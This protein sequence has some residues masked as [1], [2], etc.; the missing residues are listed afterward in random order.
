MFR[1]FIPYFFAAGHINYARYG[2]YYLRAMECLPKDVLA[3]FLKGEHV[4]RHQSGLWNGMWSD[5]FIESTFMR[6]GHGGL[7]W[8]NVETIC[9]EVLGSKYSYL[10]S[11]YQGSSRDERCQ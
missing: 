2:L 11:F 7:I 8:N 10:Q 3:T 4:M 1:V 6:C 9:F 5:M